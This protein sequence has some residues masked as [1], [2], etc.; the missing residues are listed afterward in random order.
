LLHKNEKLHT[1][2]SQHH[3]HHPHQQPFREYSGIFVVA[4]AFENALIFASKKQL[5][6]VFASAMEE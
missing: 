1:H 5:L 4:A 3:H 6:F 2:N